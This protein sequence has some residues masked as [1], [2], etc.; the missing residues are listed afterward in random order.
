MQIFVRVIKFNI[1]KHVCYTFDLNAFFSF[2]NQVPG[3]GTYGKGG[4][5]HTLLEEK[6]LK[7]ASTVGMLDA[8]ASGKRQLPEVVSRYCCFTWC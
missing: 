7:S 2:Q 5:P 4:I 6:Q 1:V 3:L 8:G